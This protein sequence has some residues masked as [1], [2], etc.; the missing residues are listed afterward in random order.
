MLCHY[1]TIIKLKHNFMIKY[2]YLI[3]T[4]YIVAYFTNYMDI[5]DILIDKY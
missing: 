2:I 3:A 5:G 1:H 4:R